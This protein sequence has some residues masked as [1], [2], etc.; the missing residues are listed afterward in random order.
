MWTK[1][2]SDYSDWPIHSKKPIRHK[3]FYCIW[4]PL[5]NFLSTLLFNV[6]YKN[7]TLLPTWRV[8]KDLVEKIQIDIL[9]GSLR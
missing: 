5:L 1:T 2:Y 9:T 8:T 7:N 6:S 3:E 4:V